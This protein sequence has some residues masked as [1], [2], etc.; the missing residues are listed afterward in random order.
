MSL[1]ADYSR[2]ETELRKLN[3]FGSIMMLLGWDEEVNLP[4]ESGALR[5]A[6]HGALAA[7]VHR[8][9]VSPSLG[10]LIRRLHDRI[11]EL[12]P[13]RR[14]VVAWA[15]RDFR[16]ATALPQELVERRARLGSESCLAWRKAREAKDFKAF[17]PWLEKQV[18]ITHEVAGHLGK[19]GAAVYD[20]CIDRHDP[21]LDA[22]FV[23]EI[24]GRLRAG[25]I[26]LT[27]EILAA[28][29]P[30]EAKRYPDCDDAAQLAFCREI[31]GALG[32]DYSRGRIDRSTHP[33]CAGDARDCRLTTRFAADN[34]VDGLFSAIH[35][36]G[37]GMYAQGL[38]ADHAGD[39][40]G[41]DAGMGVH[42]SQSRL[43]ENQVARSG[44]FWR[45]CAPKLHAAFPAWSPGE[46]PESL[47]RRM[48]AAAHTI[49]RVDADE[50]TYNQHILLRFDLERRLLDGS[51]KVRDLPEA[52]AEQSRELLG[53]APAHDGE[54]VLQD[55]HWSWGE[56]GYF[57]SYTIGNMIAAAL[58]ETFTRDRPSWQD[59]FAR[60]DFAPLLAFLRD[61][62]HRHGRIAD[63]R[64][65]CK[66]A[67]GADLAP[68]AL[69]RHLRSRY[70]GGAI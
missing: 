14:A 21:G 51:L 28:Q 16:E 12:S 55:I 25:L 7:A 13:Q 19:S 48:N 47:A 35:E 32:F 49:I 20:W 31:T 30:A 39:A 70:L 67:T 42:E 15:H 63:A 18:A 1:D 69:L 26:P 11:G 46:S 4:P 50:A 62:V 45:W 29:S 43:W 52:W 22:A 58:W 68:E 24:F 59:E 61:R 56:F 65:L 9:S 33:F 34:P 23:G 10:D 38:P 66:Q 3:E 2:L 6:Q 8:E 17:A 27:R 44:A 57:P 37:H 40:L 5:A 41:R 60:G 64:E 53:I 36:A 54:G